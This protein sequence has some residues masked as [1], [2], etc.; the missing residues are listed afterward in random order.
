MVTLHFVN[1]PYQA[2]ELGTWKP[3]IL[4]QGSSYERHRGTLLFWAL[5]NGG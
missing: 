3:V 2:L 5:L 4:A 1:R